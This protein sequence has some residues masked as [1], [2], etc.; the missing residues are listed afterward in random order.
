MWGQFETKKTFGAL[1][2]L[3]VPA[4]FGKLMFFKKNC[5]KFWRSLNGHKIW[6]NA[7]NQ[8]KLPPID[9]NFNAVFKNGLGWQKRGIES[10]IVVT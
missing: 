7:L 10:K 9:S 1:I 3:K 2:T 5:Q 6:N 4:V 8:L